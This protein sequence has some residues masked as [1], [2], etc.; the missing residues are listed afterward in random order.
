MM[1]VPKFKVGDKVKVIYNSNGSG[2]VEQAMNKIGVVHKFYNR[3]RMI[4]VK[5]DERIFADLFIVGFF[6]N[7]IEL[8]LKKGKQLLFSFMEE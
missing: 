4:Y 2:V 8:H 1:R 5:F 7:E 6:K 3:D